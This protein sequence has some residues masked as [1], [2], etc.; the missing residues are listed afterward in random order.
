MSNNY[1]L[2]NLNRAY[3]QGVLT[4]QEFKTLKGQVLN[5]R[6]RQASKGMMTILNRKAKVDMNEG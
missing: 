2:R 1:I 3:K 6:E 5:G 4:I